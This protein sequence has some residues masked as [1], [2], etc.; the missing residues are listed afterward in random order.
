MADSPDF[1]KNRRFPGIAIAFALGCIALFATTIVTFEMLQLPEDFEISL[2][3][4]TN[5]REYFI[6]NFDASRYSINELRALREVYPELRDQIDPVISS[7]DW[8]VS[9][10]IS[11]ERSRS[12]EE[13]ISRSIEESISRSIEEKE[14]R[15]KES[16]EREESISREKEKSNSSGGGSNG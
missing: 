10:S 8:S 13:S 12:I 15:E 1:K 6:E 3:E 9:V 16:R 4:Y 5:L 2:P 11:E 7:Y 14:S